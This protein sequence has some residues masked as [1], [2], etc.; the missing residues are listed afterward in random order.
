M[1]M[2]PGCATPATG[3]MRSGCVGMLTSNGTRSAPCV[4]SSTSPMRALGPRPSATDM[5]RESVKVNDAGAC[6]ETGPAG[7][8]VS[9]LTTAG[10]TMPSGVS[11]VSEPSLLS[12]TD[13]AG[14][15][16]NFTTLPSCSPCPSMRT[17]VRES[18]GAASGETSDT[19][20]AWR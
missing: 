13:A 16:P 7:D 4:A 5:S 18:I 15:A 10:P 19:L 1:V 3:V 17:A 12:A 14:S 9:T 8:M 2:A 11:A 6:A 20:G